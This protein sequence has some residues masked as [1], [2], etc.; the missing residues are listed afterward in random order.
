[1]TKLSEIIFTLFSFFGQKLRGELDKLLNKKIEEP[2]LDISYDGK[3]V[4]T[5]VVELLH[6]QN[7]H[8]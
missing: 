6:S 1:M 5:A 8:Y 7:V 4:V 3:A 2:S